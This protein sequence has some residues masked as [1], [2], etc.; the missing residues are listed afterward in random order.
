MIARLTGTVVEKTLTT[1]VLDVGGVGY[2]L[3]APTDTLDR[4]AQGS[5][6]SFSIYTHVREQS[7]ELFGFDSISK[8]EL[9]LQLISV[10]GV[11]PKMR[12]ALLSLG[13]ERAIRTAI[14]NEDGKFLTLASG[15]GKRLAEKVIVDLK[16]KVG[17]E[18]GSIVGESSPFESQSI[19]RDEALE[20]LVALG[21][22]QQDASERLRSIDPE[23]SVE[24]RVKKALSS[25]G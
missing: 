15:V 10:S 18:P 17:V 4:T 8:K 20:A 5:E 9:F 21:F 23:L 11:G 6:G 19:G 1:L 25:T 7:L 24:D 12:L 13:D 2:E 22:T 14:A 16:D 3:Y